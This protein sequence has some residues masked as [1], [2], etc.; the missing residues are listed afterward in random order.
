MRARPGEEVK[1][2]RIEMTSPGVLTRSGWTKRSFE[3]G[4]KITL[5]FGPLRSGGTAG[6]FNKAVEGRRQ[7]HAVRQ[8]RD[9]DPELA[10]LP[11]QHAMGCNVERADVKSVPTIV[12]S[13]EHRLRH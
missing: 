4:D 9:H 5:E 12:G 8:R 10:R 13:A 7:G 2:W 11:T 3:P 1:T 6:Y